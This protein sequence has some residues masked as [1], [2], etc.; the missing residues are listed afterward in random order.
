MCENLQCLWKILQA[1]QK[2][3]QGVQIFL[4]GVQ[5]FRMVWEERNEKVCGNGKTQVKTVENCA[6][7]FC[8]EAKSCGVLFV[9]FVDG[10]RTF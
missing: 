9:S 3:Q 7:F 5:I 2:I 4:Q 8:I 1:L 6:P 10:I